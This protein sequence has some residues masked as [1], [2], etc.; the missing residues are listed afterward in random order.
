MASSLI[1]VHSVGPVAVVRFAIPRIHEDEQ[2][3]LLGEQFTSLV[4]DHGCR[5]VVINFA[6]LDF[7][8]NIVIHKLLTLFRKL[9]AADGRLVLC[10]MQPVVQQYFEITRL[11]R[12][13]AI[14]PNE[15]AALR[16]EQERGE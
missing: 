16:A 7:I 8:T 1:T 6:G 4:E 14:L 3:Q 10:G 12:V 11:D 9:Q 2:A 5:R 13:F 15:E